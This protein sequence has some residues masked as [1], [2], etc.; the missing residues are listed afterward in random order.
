MYSYIG[1]QY[2]VPS[3]DCVNTQDTEFSKELVR[4]VIDERVRNDPTSS[5]LIHQQVLDCLRILPSKSYGDTSL[6]ENSN[7]ILGDVYQFYNSD[8]NSEQHKI[9]Q[10][11][12][13]R[14]EE[15][16]QRQNDRDAQII[17]L[18]EL[19]K[20]SKEATSS[21]DGE[22]R[23][24]VSTLIANLKVERNPEE[25]L[26]ECETIAI[27]RQ[28][29]PD[30][31]IDTTS[32]LP[33]LEDWACSSTSKLLL[34]QAEPMAED[35]AKDSAV[36]I[37]RYL[38]DAALPVAWYFATPQAP[39]DC[40]GWSI[41]LQTL[42][43]QLISKIPDLGLSQYQGKAM[44]ENHPMVPEDNLLNFFHYTVTKLPRCFIIVEVPLDTADASHKACAQQL[45]DIFTDMVQQALL[46]GRTLKILMVHQDTTITYSPP[47]GNL[48][49]I[50]STSIP[51]TQMPLAR[52]RLQAVRMQN[53]LTSIL[54]RAVLIAKQGVP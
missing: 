17:H 40:V 9:L 32:Y 50:Q 48:K 5:T 27:A 26:Q 6:S 39:A 38:T 1:D 14:V 34:V 23:M 52:A 46:E 11:L 42:T 10:N 18:S 51:A 4:K 24:D 44:N 29:L 49:P 25:V 28:F 8:S 31:C 45:A 41:I 16:C 20:K 30:L 13:K 2:N 36:N 47:L 3:S 7:A 37:A 19:L 15:L 21:N 54:E 43:V 53:D 12:Q 33:Y 35:A 22:H